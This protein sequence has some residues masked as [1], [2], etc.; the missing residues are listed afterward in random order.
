MKEASSLL[1]EFQSVRRGE[2]SILRALI[3]T[4]AHVAWKRRPVFVR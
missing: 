2:I 4:S 3:Q 1:S